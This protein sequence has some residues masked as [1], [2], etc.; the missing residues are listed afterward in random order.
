LNWRIVLLT[1]LLLSSVAVTVG[2][3]TI[4]IDVPKILSGGVRKVAASAQVLLEP[5]DDESPPG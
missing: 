4:N 1:I 3:T 5:I 2:I